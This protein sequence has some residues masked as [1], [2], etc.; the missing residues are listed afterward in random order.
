[1][2]EERVGERT[3]FEK[4]LLTVIG[5][6]A[7]PILGAM[8]STTLLITFT[9]ATTWSALVGSFP[10]IIAAGGL[11][12][13]YYGLLPS[14]TFGWPIHLVMQHLKLGRV[15]HYIIGGSLIAL[16]AMFVTWSISGGYGAFNPPIVLLFVS[17]GA[18]G[19]LAFWLIRRPDR[20]ASS[21]QRA[22][23]TSA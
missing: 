7:A 21:S 3:K 17:A 13:G 14:L 18:F 23:E 9:V 4:A 1:M 5:L 12:G 19:A 22:G 20:D 15:H 10:S 2:N 11:F 8:A 16:L 6:V